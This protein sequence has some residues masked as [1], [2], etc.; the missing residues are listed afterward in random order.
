MLSVLTY[1]PGEYFGEFEAIGMISP[2]SANVDSDPLHSFMSKDGIAQATIRAVGRCELL[3]ISSR[4]DVQLFHRCIERSTLKLLD[5]LCAVGQYA[6]VEEDCLAK[7]AL[8]GR[9][10]WT[11]RGEVIFM[12]GAHPEYVVLVLQGQLKVRCLLTYCMR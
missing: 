10:R 6:S 11:K 9:E 7:L 2:M 12:D 5:Q 4:A 3:Q 8:F 1:T